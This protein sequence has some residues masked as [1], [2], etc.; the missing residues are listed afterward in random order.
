[1]ENNTLFDYFRRQVLSTRSERPT[2]VHFCLK[3]ADLVGILLDHGEGMNAVDAS[4][5]TPLDLSVQCGHRSAF[6]V[7]LNR[8]ALLNYP[9]ATLRSAIR[10]TWTPEVALILERRPF[11]SPIDNETLLVTNKALFGAIGVDMA[12]C[13][14]EQ[15]CADS[16]WLCLKMLQAR[17][18]DGETALQKTHRRFR[19]AVTIHEN[20]SPIYLRQQFE[21][22]QYLEFY[23]DAPLCTTHVEPSTRGQLHHRL[24]QFQHRIALEALLL[25]KNLPIHSVAHV[26]LSY[27]TLEDVM[28]RRPPTEDR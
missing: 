23:T 8:G 25:I 18:Q 13:I 19:R 7:L 20:P 11:I 21:L 24:N 5:R 27:L 14:L 26:V 17:D 22:A 10:H 4:G 9:E 16:S 3:N 15:K 1:M 12:R 28:V 2:I 6:T